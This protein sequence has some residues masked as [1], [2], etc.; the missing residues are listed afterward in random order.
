[1]LLRRQPHQRVLKQELGLR[2]ESRQM[3]TLS[4]IAVLVLCI[5]CGSTTLETRKIVNFPKRLELSF[6]YPPGGTSVNGGTSDGETLREVKMGAMEMLTEG[7]DGA[8]DFVIFVV[9]QND[10]TEQTST[11]EA[12][13]RASI[14]AA[15]AAK[16]EAQLNKTEGKEPEKVPTPIPDEE[17]V[18]E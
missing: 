4:I 3:K 2:K 16:G 15:L 12:T 5:G 13:V 17:E 11:I 6:T 9:N 1:M 7:G 14:E 10:T 18:I 8:R